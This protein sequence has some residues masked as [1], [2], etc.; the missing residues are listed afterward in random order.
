M[1]TRKGRYPGVYGQTWA[2]R[3]ASV[4]V[5]RDS[6]E[7]GRELRERWKEVKAR[8]DGKATGRGSGDGAASFGH[9]RW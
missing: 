5:P 8:I 3:P 4:F 2:R 1:T 6:F 9:L 7:A